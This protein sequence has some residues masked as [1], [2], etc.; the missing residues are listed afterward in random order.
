MA[1]TS[2][3]A[4]LAVPA[5]PDAASTSFLTWLRAIGLFNSRMAVDADGCGEE[6]DLEWKDLRELERAIGAG[7]PSPIKA[8]ALVLNELT[9]IC[10]ED[11]ALTP[12]EILCGHS[13][14]A[15]LS[16]LLLESLRP[17][18]SGPLADLTADILDHPE[19][20]L[21]ESRLARVYAGED[22][23]LAT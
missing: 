4:L 21:G 17:L 6:F 11:P 2:R 18:L 8:A 14:E 7:P 10:D 9:Y 3:R 22:G 13:T 5:E 15:R 19:R 23:A 12:A 20:P 1:A 16:L